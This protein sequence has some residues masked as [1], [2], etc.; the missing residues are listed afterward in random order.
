MSA[1]YDSTLQ[2]A[3]NNAVDGSTIKVHD[4]T[5]TEELII[6]LNKVVTFRGGYDENFSSIV[7]T[8]NVVGNAIISDGEVEFQDF[9]IDQ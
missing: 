6:N 9:S 8:T 1:T 3:Y 7:G 2:G 5:F 4:G